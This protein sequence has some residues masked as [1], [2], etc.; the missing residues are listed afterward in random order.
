MIKPS[1][2]QTLCVQLDNAVARR[3]RQHLASGTS[4]YS[5]LNELVEVAIENLLN[6]EGASPAK[7]SPRE[8][9]TPSG[10]RDGKQLSDSPNR[11]RTISSPE[12]SFESLRGAL[13]HVTHG[14][15]AH[16]LLAQITTVSPVSVA[17]LTKPPNHLATLSSFTN[18]LSPLK[19]GVRVCA[20]VQQQVGT[21]PDLLAFRRAA[22]EAG[23]ML[24]LWLRMADDRSDSEARRWVGYPV[25]DEEM[26][27]LARFAKHF[28]IDVGI[29]GAHGPLAD[30]GLANIDDAGCVS[31]TQ[32]GWRLAALASPLLDGGPGDT[33]SPDE[34][35]LMRRLISSRMP[36]ELSSIREFLELIQ[37]ANGNQARL[38]EFLN[39][40]HP[41]WTA[42]Q[43]V[44]HRAALAG[45]LSDLGAV[46]L[47]GRG[48]SAKISLLTA[49]DEFIENHLN[50]KTGLDAHV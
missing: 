43:T 10:A 46:S 7:I 39:A 28:T 35:K 19:I 17:P 42:H 13:A 37:R 48:G 36:G 44:A 25:G 24:G 50:S 14:A 16:P 32:D 27:T 40:R 20:N 23:R 38:D 3:A 26:K 2:T 45:R 33:C 34:A 21:G 6:M 41:D 5:S 8:S 31:L 12:W 9:R 49:A 47:E 4:G 22:A 18:R 15:N 30:L 1:Q 29:A 11:S